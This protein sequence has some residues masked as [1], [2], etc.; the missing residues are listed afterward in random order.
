MT[1]ET[2]EECV[3][4]REGKESEFTRAGKLNLKRLTLVLNNN[5]CAK[6]ANRSH[7]HIKR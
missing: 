6:S 7:R 1:M 3:S 2:E 5:E 4:A